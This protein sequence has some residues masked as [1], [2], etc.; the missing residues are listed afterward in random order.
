MA[1]SDTDCCHGNQFDGRPE[2]EHCIFTCVLMY[3]V[4]VTMSVL[5]CTVTCSMCTVLMCVLFISR[6]SATDTG[7][8]VAR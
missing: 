1:V 3:V 5:I 4:I 7:Q 6:S 8:R 2:G